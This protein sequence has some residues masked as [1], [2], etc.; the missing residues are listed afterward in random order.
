MTSLFLFTPL[1]F[2]TNLNYILQAA[3]L[4]TGIYATLCAGFAFVRGRKDSLLVLI[5]PLIFWITPS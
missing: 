5:G 4:L 3:A 1:S 2:V